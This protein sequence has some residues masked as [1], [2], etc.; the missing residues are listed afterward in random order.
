MAGGWS[1]FAPRGARDTTPRVGF[2][3]LRVCLMAMNEEVNVGLRVAPDG[4]S[5]AM[6]FAILCT[7]KLLEELDL[8]ACRLVT[9][10]GLRSLPGMERMRVLN[11]SRSGAACCDETAALAAQLW[12][13]SLE[14]LSLEGGAA[15]VSDAALDILAS[16]SALRSLDISQAAVTEH[17]VKDFV[18]RSPALKTI[19]LTGCRGLPRP[20]RVA[21]ATSLAA[22]RAALLLDIR[23]NKRNTKT[24]SSLSL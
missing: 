21:S 19:T 22:L 4:P 8:S 3:N 2:P 1:I 5:D 16:C 13:A 14:E 10:Q 23:D 7:S 24:K 18:T 9:T 11:L 12:G 17:G 6:L 15:L 20:L